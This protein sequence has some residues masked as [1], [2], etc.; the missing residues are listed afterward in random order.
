MA[1]LGSLTLVNEIGADELRA[2]S[3][4]VKTL[5]QPPNPAPQSGNDPS[6]KPHH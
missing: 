3:A 4:S 5:A 1:W 6:P 2:F